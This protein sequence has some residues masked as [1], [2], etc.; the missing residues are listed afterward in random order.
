MRG[1]AGQLAGR[2]GDLTDL[3]AQLGEGGLHAHAHIGRAADDIHQLGFAAVHLQ[4]VELLAF[5]MLLHTLDLSDNH[6]GQIGA[7]LEDFVLHLSGGQGELMDQRHQVNA[8]QIHE[9]LDPVHRNI[10]YALTSINYSSSV[11]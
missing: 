8:G 9:F 7:L 6:A 4:Q 2:D 11:N 5:G 10:H 1:E 3:G